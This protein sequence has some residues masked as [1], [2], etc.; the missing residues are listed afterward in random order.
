VTERHVIWEGCY[1]IRDL[2]G[3]PTSDGR[4]TTSGVFLRGDSICRLTDR[5]RAS[6]LADGVR[7]IVDLRR[8]AELQR[9]PNPFANVPEQVAYL[10]LPFN[11]AA[12]EERIRAMPTSADRYRA[13]LDEGR[14]RITAIMTALARAERA[15]LFHCYG[16][17]DRTGM[18]AA[19]L[20]RLASV[21]DD[22]IVRDYVMTDE[23][24]EPLY[25]KWRAEMDEERRARFDGLIAEASA[26][27]EA[28]LDHLDKRYG[29]VEPYLAGGGVA[30]EEIAGLRTA[31]LS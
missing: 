18:V 21:P 15:V 7:T 22:E 5:G 1:N 4:T 2:G 29:G 12:I 23:R 10:H 17:R 19:I 27:I 20:L 6:L 30:N 16:G 25:G 24:M 9:D 3:L 14:D 31:L 26:P 11:D 8:D 13:M 28:A